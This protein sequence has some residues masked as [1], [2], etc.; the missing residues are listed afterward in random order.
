MGLYLGG[1][2]LGG[3]LKWDFTVYIKPGVLIKLKST[4][5][6]FIHS[7]EVN[8]IIKTMNGVKCPHIRGQRWSNESKSPSSGATSKGIPRFCPAYPGAVA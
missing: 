3:A 5:E 2:K 6:Y 1:L 4:I 8:V 7:S